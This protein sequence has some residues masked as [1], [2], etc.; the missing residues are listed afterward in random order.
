MSPPLT[1]IDIYTNLHGFTPTWKA[2]VPALSCITTEKL[3]G[4]AVIPRL[5][6]KVPTAWDSISEVVI[7]R[8]VR[9]TFYDGTTTTFDEYRISRVEDSSGLDGVTTI[10]GGGPI[11]DLARVDTLMTATVGSRSTLSYRVR[12]T[13]S[14]LITNEIVPMAAGATTIFVVGTVTSSASVD[15]VLEGD[16]PLSALLKL[17]RLLEDADRAT[18]WLSVTRTL[19]VYYIHIRTPTGLGYAPYLRTGRNLRSLRRT[20]DASRMATRLYVLDGVENAIGDNQWEVTAVSLNTY[21][22]I[23]GIDGGYSP[24]LRADALNGYYVVDDAGGTHQ[25]TDSAYPGRLYMAST[26]GISVGE[27]VSVRA[28]SSKT[29]LPYLEDTTAQATYGVLINKLPAIASRYTNY[30]LNPDLADWTGALPTSW[31]SPSWSDPVKTT[32]AGYWLTGGCSGRMDGTGGTTRD[33]QC[34]RSVYMTAGQ[35]CTVTAWVRMDS[36]S[37]AGATGGKITFTNPQTSATEDVALDGTVSGLD[38]LG[39]WL[40]V[41]RT[42]NITSSGTKTVTL[43][44]YTAN[45]G[46]CDLY[47]DAAMVS[48]ASAEVAFQKSSGPAINWQ[49]AIATLTTSAS[50]ITSYEV[51]LVDLYRVDPVTWSQDDFNVGDAVYITEPDLGIDTT[52]NAVTIVALTTDHLAPANTKITLSTRQ[53]ELTALLAEAA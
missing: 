44:F 8:V 48:F 25:I 19:T 49:S 42:Y 9:L 50:P 16:T 2:A 30:F 28:D 24:V 29:E 13:G 36:F 51:D 20:R 52:G 17:L 5:V 41:S 33:F 14:N 6:L 47:V 32:T 45:S 15:L 46:N 39:V 23:E 34:Q 10:T 3:E 31:T 22:D 27:W 12:D 4:K 7:G 26:S 43:Y 35:T 21:I 38:T 11:L 53:Q 18:Y 37:T 40:S 1:R